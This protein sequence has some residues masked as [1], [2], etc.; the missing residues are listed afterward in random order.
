VEAKR[1]TVGEFF[2]FPERTERDKAPTPVSTVGSCIDF[3]LGKARE[4]ADKLY[5]MDGKH[6][7]FLGDVENHIALVL[8]ATEDLPALPVIALQHYRCLNLTGNGNKLQLRVSGTAI[9]LCS[10]NALPSPKFR[11]YIAYDQRFSQIDPFRDDFSVVK[12]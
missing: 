1:M 12:L 6:R 2:G 3:A 4:D 9:E 8:L 11:I 7:G 10:A 5:D